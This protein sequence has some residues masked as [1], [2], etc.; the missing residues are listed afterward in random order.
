M[1]VV[2]INRIA[3]I[4]SVRLLLLLSVVCEIFDEK[5][6]DVNCQYQWGGTICDCE[7]LN[8][9]DNSRINVLLAIFY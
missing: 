1:A 2:S 9:V 8:Y 6:A 5:Y 7:N 3:W 4:L